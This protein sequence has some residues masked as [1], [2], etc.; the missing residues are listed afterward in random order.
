MELTCDNCPSRAN[1][2]QVDTDGDG[3]GDACDDDDDADGVADP[4]TTVRAAIIQLKPIRT[5]PIYEVMRATTMTMT[6]AFWT[7]KIIVPKCSIPTS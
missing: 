6:M 5:E 7:L 3:L 1:S 4:S 2:D